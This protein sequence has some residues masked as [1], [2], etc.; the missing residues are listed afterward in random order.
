MYDDGYGS[1]NRDCPTASAP[2]CWGHRDI[3]LDPYGHK[4][5]LISG[6]GSDRQSGLVSIAQL[7]VAGKGHAPAFTYT[8]AAAVA[9]GAG[10]RAH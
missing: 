8:W 7:F 5:M 1:Y 3:I 9:H 2:G 10:G 6:A 4:P